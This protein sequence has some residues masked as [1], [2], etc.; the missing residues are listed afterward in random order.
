MKEMVPRAGI[1]PAT[2]PLGG[3]RAIHCTTEALIGYGLR[4]A[5]HITSKGMQ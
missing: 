3:G 1:E 4:E 2:C 5:G